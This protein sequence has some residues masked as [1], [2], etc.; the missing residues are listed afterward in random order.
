[1]HDGGH[2]QTARFQV[3]QTSVQLRS[4]LMFADYGLP[5]V[6]PADGACNLAAV[7][8]RRDGRQRYWCLRT[9]RT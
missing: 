9:K 7:G 2:G 1:M 4:Q 3:G 5:V 8:R 6:P